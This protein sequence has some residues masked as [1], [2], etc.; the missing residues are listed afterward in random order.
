MHIAVLSIHPL[1][2]TRIANHLSTLVDAGHAV[3]YINW[4]PAGHTLPTR[5]ELA[6]VQLVRRERPSTVGRN[7]ALLARMLLWFYRQAVRSGAK[8]IHLHDGLILPVALPLRAIHG[9]TLV[10]DAHERYDRVPGVYGGYLRACLR[11]ALPFVAACV[12]VAP[13]T[14]P[15]RSRR[16]II[17]PNHQSRRDLKLVGPRPQDPGPLVVYFGTLAR[18]DRDVD[19]L[20][21]LA[22]LMLDRNPLIR[23]RVGGQVPPD[24]A[25][26][27]V[28]RFQA[29]AQT[30]GDRFQW[31]GAMPRE[32]VVRQTAHASLGLLLMKDV[33]NYRGS[34]PNKVFEYLMLGVPFA[35]TDGFAEA[36]EVLRSGAG[37]LLPPGARAEEVAEQLLS[38]LDDADRLALMRRA[39]AELGER[40][41][42]E[43]SSQAYLRL[44]DELTRA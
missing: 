32:E 9:R 4:S 26:S 20:L 18:A 10:F 34:S 31:L 7:P 33:P 13:S 40:Y 37:L 38:L 29:L 15:A 30:Y 11:C 1:Y 36:P 12:G 35:A 22:Q 8:L 25:A 39:G 43:T 23:F 16:S 24:D 17:V 19:L 6:R 28:P 42:W 5:P 21:A 3:T 2:D 27:L 14:V 44:Y 41:A